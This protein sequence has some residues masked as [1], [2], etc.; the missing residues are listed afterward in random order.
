MK[1]LK[2]LVLV[3]AITFSSAI[4]AST[5]PIEN[6]E[7]QTV[8]ET[9]GELL[10][11]PKIQFEKDMNA[12]VKL[13]INDDNEIVVLS[14]DTQSEVFEGFIKKRLNYKKISNEAKG[15]LK[16]FIIPVTITSSN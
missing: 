4:S 16:T 14:V 6:V 1:V 10:K 9:V 5:N 7:P 12:R 2:M 11:N 3:V 13:T 15:D 8:T